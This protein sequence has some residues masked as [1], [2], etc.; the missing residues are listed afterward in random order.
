MKSVALMIFDLDGTLVTS[1]NDIAAA[2]NH[3]LTV[4]GKPTLPPAEIMGLVGDGVE[5]LVQEAIGD[6]YSSRFH[7]A[8]TIFSSY[9][10]AHILDGTDLYPGVAEVLEH[11][12]DK[13]KVIITN[14]RIQ[15][16]REITDALNI[17]RYFEE[18]I[19]ADSTS[20]KKPDARLLRPLLDKFGVG[21]AETVV[22]G[23][24]INDILLAKNT[25]AISCALL[26]GLS[27][28]ETLQE[29]NPDFLCNDIREVKELF[30]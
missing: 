14:K 1:G 7:E 22:I 15:F 9:Y 10:A 27:L 5:K 26:G 28:K 17:S 4:L 13:N 16:T 30:C 29:L 6:A 12:Q 2:I 20:Y 19:G 11:F 25:G 21:G 18:I 24:G 23:D 8:L 3:M